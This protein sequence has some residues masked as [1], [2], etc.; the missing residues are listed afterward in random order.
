MLK[1]TCSLGGAVTAS[2]V[3]LMQCYQR[4]TAARKIRGKFSFF[5]ESPEPAG[6]CTA[7]T[8]PSVERT[9]EIAFLLSNR[10]ELSSAEARVEGIKVVMLGGLSYE[11]PRTT[12]GP[13][14]SPSVGS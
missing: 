4:E 8:R 14:Y 5:F 9:E 11:P 3:A 10:V 6:H 1:H 7:T 13:R 12:L 2:G